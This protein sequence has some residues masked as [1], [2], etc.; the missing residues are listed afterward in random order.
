MERSRGLLRLQWRQPPTI[1]LRP[2][3]ADD[4]AGPAGR[5]GTEGGGASWLGA[6]SRRRG[7]ASR[8]SRAPPRLALSRRAGRL[9]KSL[10]ANGGG[11]A[12]ARGPAG[13]PGAT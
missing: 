12:R 1:L 11:G 5:G 2:R 8:C 7:E 9:C 4:Y 3:Q 10:A 6:G 13:A